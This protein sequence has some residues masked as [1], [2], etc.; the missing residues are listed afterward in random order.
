MFRYI[1]NYLN[2]KK[3]NQTKKMNQIIPENIENKNTNINSLIVMRRRVSITLPYPKRI[4]TYSILQ[5][6]FSTQN[7]NILLTEDE[8]KSLKKIIKH[9][10]YILET[11]DDA[12]ATI[13]RKGRME[14]HD[15]PKVVY[16]VYHILKPNRYITSEN[17]VNII[18]FIVDAI[19]DSFGYP[20]SLLENDIIAKQ[21]ILNISFAL[22]T[23]KL[24]E[25]C[26]KY[27]FSNW[28]QINNNAS[29][30]STFG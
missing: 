14:L 16:M 23:A 5:N 24:P 9:T 4:N 19:L 7:K 11:I 21:T 29:S 3:N 18:K 10:P 15:I 28:L 1:K 25:P 30:F 20:L 12:I 13:I 8:L 27:F 17:A 2:I 26:P 22:L 6:I